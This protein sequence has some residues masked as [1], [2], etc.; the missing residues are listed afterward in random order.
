MLTADQHTALLMVIADLRIEVA[1]A[2]AENAH[3]RAE[4]D[5]RDRRIAELT[6][7]EAPG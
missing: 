5:D 6:P 4:L 1:N 2:N 7:T 3:L